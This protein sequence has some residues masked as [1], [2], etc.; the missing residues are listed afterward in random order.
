MRI[1]DTTTDNTFEHKISDQELLER[2]VGSHPDNFLIP[3]LGVV[4]IETLYAYLAQ[5]KLVMFAYENESLAVI[6]PG[7]VFN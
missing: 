3:T 7:T 5:I 4:P 2:D 1:T 6:D